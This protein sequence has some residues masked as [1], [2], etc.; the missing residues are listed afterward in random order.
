ME[1]ADVAAVVS[2]CPA[3]Q[4]CSIA[5]KPAVSITPLVQLTQLTRLDVK[6]VST[7]AFASIAKLTGLDTLQVQL[8]SA[9][10]PEAML[11]LTV[12][13]CLTDMSIDINVG[14]R[15]ENPER[16]KAYENAWC[17]LSEVSAAL[18]LIWGGAGHS[19]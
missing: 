16:Q 2:C 9:E 6:G 12:L 13:Q 5:I 7:S 17:F 4:E 14:N 18:C 15:F 10:E 19:L 1:A 3:L 8:E 11:A